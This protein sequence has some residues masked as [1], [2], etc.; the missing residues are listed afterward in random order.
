LNRREEGDGAFCS[1][2]FHLPRSAP[3]YRLT[4]LPGFCQRF[5]SFLRGSFLPPLVHLAFFFS[6][7][8]PCVVFFLLISP[9]PTRCFVFLLPL[10]GSVDGM[11]PVI[12]VLVSKWLTASAQVPFQ[13]SAA[14]TPGHWRHGMLAPRSVSVPPWYSSSWTG[15][16]GV[17]SILR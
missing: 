6:H 15:R 1:R 8:F 4:F 9:R 3:L 16:L 7:R 14:M 13:P 17:I 11:G 10:K 2:L 12:D 5:F